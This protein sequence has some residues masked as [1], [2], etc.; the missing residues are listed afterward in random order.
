MKYNKL[1]IIILLI[2]SIVTSSCNEWLDVSPKTQIKG[3]DN[4]SSEQGFKDALTGVYLLMTE[5]SV[6]GQELTYGMLDAMAQYYTGLAQASSYNFDMAFDYSNA[7]VEA[8]TNAVWSRMYSIIANDNE[9][10]KQI[11]SASETMF[12]G[13]NFHLIRG[14]AYG[15]RAFLHFDLA[16]LWGKSYKADKNHKCIPYV[17]TVTPD[18][19]P[20][21]TVA[22][23]MQKALDDLK[24][25][26][27]E[28]S[29]DPAIASNIST[30]ADDT[31][32][33]RNRTFKMNYYAVKMLQARIYLYMS[34]YAKAREAADAVINQSTFQWTPETEINTSESSRR[35]C[36]FSQ[37]LL[38]CLYDTSLRSRYSNLFTGSINSLRMS[39]NSYQAIYEL[40]NPGF[41]GDYRY[42][43]QNVELDGN[44]Y[45]TK[46]QQPTSGNPE[47]MF[48]IP[49]MRIS[50][51][52][53]IAA[54]C[55]LEQDG[56]IA[57]ALELINTVRRKRNLTDDLQ[58][59]LSINDVRD[60][61]RK[62]YT[63]EFMCEG[64]LYYFF[65]RLNYEA[66]PVYTAIEN[67]VSVNYVT[68]N[69]TFL[70]PDDEVEYGSR[71]NDK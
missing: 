45:C 36:I 61:L 3:D 43:Y 53:Y 23:V 58:T 62:E 44:H 10:I 4:F 47:F 55:A 54:E 26:E 65:K 33:E 35:N 6:Y 15:L 12:T 19:Y 66:I 24:I 46:L 59:S 25:A 13:R 11:D 56:N 40:Y 18:V 1:S 21:N 2:A 22:E 39:E 28:L 41:S 57:D 20:L 32:Y 63:K 70:L 30:S 67:A 5:T 8:R 64:Q 9:L 34:E 69:Y 71:Q 14:E 42:A 7:S 38:F 51:A 49:L 16:R 50:E 52:Y 48:R 29:I 17:T 60:E 31:N 37:E 68:P 27:A